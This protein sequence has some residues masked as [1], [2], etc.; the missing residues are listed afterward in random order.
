MKTLVEQ[1]LALRNIDRSVE[2]CLTV[3][4]RQRNCLLASCIPVVP[5]GS[6]EKC[7]E[8][9]GGCDGGKERSNSMFDDTL[10]VV[11]CLGARSRKQSLHCTT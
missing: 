2:Y 4:Q 7:V 9:G 6:S 10:M 11:V 3:D 5:L 8:V 1:W